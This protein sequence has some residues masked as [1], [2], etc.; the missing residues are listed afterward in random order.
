LNQNKRILPH[1]DF[2]LDGFK[3]L[4]I[5]RT[6]HFSLFSS[7]ALQ[8]LRLVHSLVQL[9]DRRDH[10]SEQR[11]S[12]LLLRRQIAHFEELDNL[13]LGSIGHGCSGPLGRTGLADYLPELGRTETESLTI[14]SGLLI[15]NI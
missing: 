1:R 4:E 3:L 10:L 5:L 12:R 13:W 14:I 2:Q 6:R 11:V 15:N 7:G 8:L 9:I